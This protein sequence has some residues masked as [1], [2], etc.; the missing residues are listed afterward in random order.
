MKKRRG[1]LDAIT[2]AVFLFH[3]GLV[4]VEGVVELIIIRVINEYARA[5]GPR[6]SETLLSVTSFPMSPVGWSYNQDRMKMRQ[7]A[8]M[9]ASVACT[10]I[11]RVN[12]SWSM[13][14]PTE[15]ERR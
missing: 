15:C 4:N 3:Q 7:R 1:Y 6:N 12:S 5:V 14:N 10:I 9:I 11:S 13:D 2:I 8:H